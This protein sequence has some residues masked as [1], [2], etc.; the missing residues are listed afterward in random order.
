MKKIYLCFVLLLMT[1]I[2]VGCGVKVR[3][4]YDDASLYSEYKEEV[5]LTNEE[6]SKVSIDWI[7]GS[8]EIKKGEKFTVYEE[9]INGTYKPLYWYAN[10]GKLKVAYCKSGTTN[11]DIT[12]LSK[13]LVIV[14]NKDLEELDIDNVSS[15]ISIDLNEV[16]EIDI[17]NVS[18]NIDILVNKVKK[19]D[20]DTVS[21]N[22]SLKVMDNSLL[23]IIDFDSTSSNLTLLLPEGSAFEVD[24]NAISGAYNNEFDN[25][26]DGFKVD[27]DSVSGNLNIKKIE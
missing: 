23:K 8:I 13:K 16:S 1:S 22:C 10:E 9:V 2:L 24:R 12:G 18:G 3:I 25:S 14:T 27:F 26:S 11:K 5:D 20:V 15:S 6:I 7:S 21:G 17:D 19:V 4:K